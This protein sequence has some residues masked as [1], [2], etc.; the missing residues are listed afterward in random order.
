MSSKLIHG[1]GEVQDVALEI[2]KSATNKALD[3]NNNPITFVSAVGRSTQSLTRKGRMLKDEAGNDV[4][5][6][7]K[8]YKP[9]VTLYCDKKF[10][11][12]AFTELQKAPVGSIVKIN[13][14]MDST[15]IVRNPDADDAKGKTYTDFYSRW[16]VTS[17]K[18]VAS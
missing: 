11:P 15:A 7:D 14:E 17:C 8:T 13:A 4:Q 6:P 3:R 2:T 9:Q 10:F 16:N 12:E 18:I 5:G 1:L